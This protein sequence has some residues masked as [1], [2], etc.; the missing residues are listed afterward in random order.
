MNKF[1]PRFIFFAACFAQASLATSEEASSL[2]VRRRDYHTMLQSVAARDPLQLY[3]DEM[4]ADPEACGIV[5]TE[6]PEGYSY[7]IIPGMEDQPMQELSQGQQDYYFRW[8]EQGSP[9]GEEERIS[10][11]MMYGEHEKADSEEAKKKLALKQQQQERNRQATDEKESY[12]SGSEQQSQSAA[13]IKERSGSH[14]LPRE[15]RITTL[16]DDISEMTGDY[17]T[18]ESKQRSPSFS[19]KGGASV[20]LL[21]QAEDK[22]RKARKKVSDARQHFDFS[23]RQW[24][25]SV[26]LEIAFKNHS[27][28]QDRLGASF[29]NWQHAAI[30]LQQAQAV[31]HEALSR[32]DPSYADLHQAVEAAEEEVHRTFQ[33]HQAL[34]F[35]A[36]SAYQNYYFAQQ[37]AVQQGLTFGVD[38]TSAFNKAQLHANQAADQ[39]EKCQE[40]VRRIKFE[41]PNAPKQKETI[42]LPQKITTPVQKEQAAQTAG[43]ISESKAGELEK[44]RQGGSLVAPQQADSISKSSAA[45]SDKTSYKDQGTQISEEDLAAWNREALLKKQTLWKSRFHKMVEKMKRL[46]EA[47][48]ADFSKHLLHEVSREF[49]PNVAQVSLAE[50][51]D[52]A[53]ERHLAEVERIAEE[54][55]EEQVA[56]APTIADALIEEALSAPWAKADF[57]KIAKQAK[58]ELLLEK[59]KKIFSDLFFSEG[60]TTEREKREQQQESVASIR[61]AKEQQR[62]EME[63][64]CTERVNLLHPEEAREKEGKQQPEVKSL[65]DNIASMIE[66]TGDV[67]T[68]CYRRPYKWCSDTWQFFQDQRIV[69]VQAGEETKKFFA[70]QG[71]SIIDVPTTE[72]AWKNGQVAQQIYNELVVKRRQEEAA[73]KA[74]P[75]ERGPRRELGYFDQIPLILEGPVFRRFVTSF[76]EKKI[77]DPNRESDERAIDYFKEIGKFEPRIFEFWKKSA[78]IEEKLKKERL[79]KAKWFMEHFPDKEEMLRLAQQWGAEWRERLEQEREQKKAMSLDQDRLAEEEKRQKIAQA[80]IDERAAQE[81]KRQ[82]IEKELLDQEAKEKLRKQKVKKKPLRKNKFFD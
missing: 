29:N 25:A 42:A 55:K 72:Y 1:L 36:Q 65:A 56:L 6:T 33:E 35:P 30:S 21:H 81:E 17:T 11:L 62:S 31:A 34:I 59:K 78:E 68:Q 5:R 63:R 80:V 16:P 79:E 4:A 19:P 12:S 46:K 66:K 24:E 26:N 39:L 8:I 69:S 15:I 38:Y 70:D 82:K 61:R 67:L 13:A 41:K 18:L 77:H 53:A 45:D 58:R 23:Q 22:L 47:V 71:R 20:T 64:F 9:Q 44:E 60:E 75:R 32:N 14:Q 76:F 51:Q 27:E 10:P 73:L 37:S 57:K 3:S 54:Q 49:I 50:E 7:T 48:V 74:V 52:A 43:E 2:I 40:A 28:F